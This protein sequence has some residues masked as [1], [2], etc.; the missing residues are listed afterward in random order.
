[1]EISMYIRVSSPFLPLWSSLFVCIGKFSSL[2]SV[3]VHL[4]S[5]Q[6]WELK[7]S[8]VAVRWR[9]GLEYET[10][11]RSKRWKDP[12]EGQ[13]VGG[14]W[15]LLQLG[16]DVSIGS[17]SKDD[18]WYCQDKKGIWNWE[19]WGRDWRR[20]VAEEN[21]GNWWEIKAWSWRELENI[22]EGFLQV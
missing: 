16:R 18:K 12:P 11:G 5:K 15:V 4:M 6:N 7:S 17:N 19:S 13:R 14:T 22:H 10:G 21:V 2:F 9:T 20:T 8:L 1:M 3:F